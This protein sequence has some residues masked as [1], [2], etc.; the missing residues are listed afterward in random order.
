[1]NCISDSSSAEDGAERIY[2][3]GSEMF[4]FSNPEV[5]KLIK[6]C[7]LIFPMSFEKHV[8][9]LCVDN[10]NAIFQSLR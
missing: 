7:S 2:P 6:V 4:G 1:M 5:F 8:S 10:P 9:C 3:S